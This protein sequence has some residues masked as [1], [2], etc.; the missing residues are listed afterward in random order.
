MRA[1]VHERPIDLAA[2]LNE[3][4]S[5]ANGAALLFVG[6]VRDLNDGRAVTGIEYFAY[7]AMAGRE[8][9]AIVGEAAERF[10][11]PHIVVEHR[12]GYLALGEASVAVAVAHPRRAAAYD[13]SRYVVEE[14]K[15]RVP[16][17]K[18]EHYADG[19]RE[20]VDPTS[21]RRGARASAT[22]ASA[23]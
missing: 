13:A 11:T 22:G 21:A 23:R 1:D 10:A 20:W 9:A 7:L 4:A 12:I 16:I 2:L 3:V 19:T 8:L 5:P 17:W 15:R 6:A 14:L 18:R